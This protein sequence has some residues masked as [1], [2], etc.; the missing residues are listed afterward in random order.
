VAALRPTAATGPATVTAEAYCRANAPTLT[1]AVVAT[2]IPA[3]SFVSP[4]MATLDAA[5]PPGR[6]AVAGGFTA[7][8][9]LSGT[10]A[11]P[12][13]FQRNLAGTGWHAVFGN[14]FTSAEPIAVYAYCGT[15][16]VLSVSAATNSSTNLG[17]MTASA[18]GCPADHVMVKKQVR[19]HGKKKTKKV[20]RAV[21][22]TPVSGGFIAPATTWNGSSS[23]GVVPLTS[24]RTSSG[25]RNDAIHLGT[26]SQTL[27]SI[28]YCAL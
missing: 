4:T 11:S 16:P 12:F 14:A 7:G 1:E 9:E 13:E 22:T 27:T 2:T 20:L 8:A 5:C 17:S 3:G 28:A 24:S 10:G 26:T 21:P 18:S 19:R 6:Q 23:D 25:W 15:K